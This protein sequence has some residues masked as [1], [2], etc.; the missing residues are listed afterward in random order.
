M[1]KPHFPKPRFE[2]G[3]T[4]LVTGATGLVGS[5]IAEQLVIAGYQVRLVT[6]KAARAEPLQQHLE[7]LHGKG[8][9]EIVELAD[10]TDAKALDQILQGVSGIVHVATDASMSSN[11]DAVIVYVEK[12]LSSL[13][14]AAERTSTVKLVV[15]T[16]SST[17]AFTGQE[18]QP[19]VVTEQTFTDHVV[20]LAYRTPDSHPSK[21]ALTCE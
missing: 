14:E 16:S 12:M 7:S 19:I 5:N 15:L 1:P 17:A 11:V 18:P 2:Q 3:A 6:R 10:A 20:D 21:A 4:V 13:L 8:S 9:A